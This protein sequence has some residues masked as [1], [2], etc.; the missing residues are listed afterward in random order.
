M[1]TYN[2]IIEL[3]RR[4]I[5]DSAYAT[6]EQEALLAIIKKYSVYD[7]YSSVV[8]AIPYHNTSTECSSDVL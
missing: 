2:V 7:Y 8:T 4:L 5:I 3:S 1:Q 6:N